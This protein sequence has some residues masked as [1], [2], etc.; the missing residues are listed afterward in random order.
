MSLEDV[1]PQADLVQKPEQEQGA[2]RPP[3]TSAQRQPAS[4]QPVRWLYKGL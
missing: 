4:Q 3:V 1:K 2:A